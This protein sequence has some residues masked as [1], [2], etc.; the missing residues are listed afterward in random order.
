MRKNHRLLLT[1]TAAVTA[2]ACLPTLGP[3]PAPIPTL[4]PSEPLTA[5]VL[6]SSAAAA[7]T[8]LN[9]SP[10]ATATPLPTHT[11]TDTPTPT[12]TFLF[13]VPT[14]AAPATQIQIGHSDLDF[15]CQVIS[16]EPQGY[17]SATSRFF[18]RWVVAN[19]GKVTWNSDNMDYQYVEGDK[20]H[21]QSIYDFPE[22]V[23]PGSIVKLEVDMQA[24]STPGEYYT[25]WRI[26]NGNR[27]FC[28]MELR[29]K[30]N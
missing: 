20:I 13:L 11:P 18:G 2:L 8:A 16:S 29:I 7:Q 6:T 12:A 4:D 27:N 21:L 30:V 23:Q 19:I 28:P 15:D 10:T 9:A 24:P 22:S 17:I 26:N 1:L 14:F 25:K 5:I 3:A